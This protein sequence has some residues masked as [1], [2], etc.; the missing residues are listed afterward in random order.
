MV[1][2]EIVYDYIMRSKNLINSRLNSIY[3]IY[4]DFVDIFD[5]IREKDKVLD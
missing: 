2:N 1:L 3:K 4:D 5:K